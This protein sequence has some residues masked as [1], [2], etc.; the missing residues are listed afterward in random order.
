MLLARILE[1]TRMLPARILETTPMLSARILETKPM[2][3][4]SILETTPMLQARIFV[5]ATPML[6]LKYWSWWRCWWASLALSGTVRMAPN[7]PR[8]CASTHQLIHL[9]STM[10][11]KTIA[12]I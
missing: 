1:T 3:Q 12:C 7:T 4:A 9:R 5:E 8:F 11:P 10:Q 6:Q 2:L